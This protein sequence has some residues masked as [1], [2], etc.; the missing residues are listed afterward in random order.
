M[1]A[2]KM[3]HIYRCGVVDQTDIGCLRLDKKFTDRN[4]PMSRLYGG[5]EM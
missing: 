1:A 5:V 3:V 2:Y 4:C